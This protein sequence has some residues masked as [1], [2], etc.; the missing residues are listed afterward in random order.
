MNPI[1]S[2]GHAEMPPPVLSGNGFNSAIVLENDRAVAP[3]DGNN[4]AFPRDPAKYRDD[5]WELG[6]TD[7]RLG[8]PLAEAEAAVEWRTTVERNA[9]LADLRAQLATAKA[10]VAAITAR[11]GSSPDLLTKLRENYEKLKLERLDDVSNTSLPLGILYT[12]VGFSLFIA[13][14]PLSLTLVAKALKIALRSGDVS[15]GQLFRN[16]IDVIFG[17]TWE[18]MFLAIGIAFSGVFIKF[19]LDEFV[20]KE[21]INGESDK[22]SPRRSRKTPILMTAFLFL[23]LTTTILLG[24]FRAYNKWLDQNQPAIGY[25]FILESLTFIGLTLMFPVIGGVCFSAGWRRLEKAKQYYLMKWSLWRLETKC[26]RLQNNLMRAQ[27]DMARVEQSLNQEELGS[28]SEATR[29]LNLNL[30][31]HGYLRGYTLPETLHTDLGL[32]QQARRV[33]EK[34]LAGNLRTRLWED[35][36]LK[37]GKIGGQTKL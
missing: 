27:S 37:V 16:P 34:F 4:R 10:N 29:L 2:N 14:L 13:D 30:Y 31:K 28:T 21:Q 5:Y 22:S 20:F 1:K 6:W 3:S 9:K 18:A 33:I 23:F 35:I 32:Y 12:V 17:P 36:N 19:Y 15:V 24:V 11:I 7:G 8:Q 26:E 25:G